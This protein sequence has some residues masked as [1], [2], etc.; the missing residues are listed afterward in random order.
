MANWSHAPVHRLEKTG[1][2]MV[3]TGTYQKQHF[4]KEPERLALLHDSLLSIA[5]EFDWRLQAW[6]VFSNHYHIVGLSPEDP[7]SL[8]P[9]ISKLHTSTAAKVNEMDGCPGRKVWHEFWDTHLTNERSYFAR[10]RYVHNNPVHHGIVP[11]AS[12][13]AWC[14]AAWFENTS[15]RAFFNVVNTFPIDKVKVYDEF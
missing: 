13:Y 4:F 6:V 15:D 10:L 14:S 8:R 3:T 11:V 1:A 7:S 2:Y 9:F 5:E 12:Q